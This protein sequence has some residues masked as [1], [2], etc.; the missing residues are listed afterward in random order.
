LWR[1]RLDDGELLRISLAVIALIVHLSCRLA[2]LG[3]DDW[4][5]W[6]MRPVAV[7]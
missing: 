6:V 3:M 5:Q 1:P 7:S 4:L 2:K